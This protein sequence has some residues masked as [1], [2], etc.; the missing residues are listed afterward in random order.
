MRIYP[1]CPLHEAE[2]VDSI[3]RERLQIDQ[4]RCDCAEPDEEIFRGDAFRRVILAMKRPRKSHRDL[5]DVQTV[6]EDSR[7]SVEIVDFSAHGSRGGGFGVEE[8]VDESQLG[9]GELS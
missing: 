5:G 1:E 6:V 4:S 3:A 8:T 2:H 7:D 9:V